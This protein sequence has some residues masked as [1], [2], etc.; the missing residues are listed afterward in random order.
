MNRGRALAAVT[1]GFWAGAVPFSNLAARR[2]AGVDLRSYGTGTVSGTGLYEVTGIA[3]LVVVGLLELGKG[4]LGPALAGPSRPVAGALAGAAAVVGHNWSPFLGGAGG[5]GI[6]PAMGALVPSAPAAAAV[7]LAGLA[8]GKLAGETA[9]GCFVADL[10]LVPLAARA[11]GRRGAL[12]AGAVLLPMVV[13]RL[14]GNGPPSQPG[15]S[16][17]WWRLLL[18]R[19]A[20]GRPADPADRERPHRPG[21]PAR[22]GL[23]EE[24]R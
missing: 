20:P 23:P 5:R 6:S 18:D 14:A 17:Y 22:P 2:L 12:A 1:A 7:L 11:H 13:K 9:V 24:R 8:V 4:A 21:L 10:A 16:V 3:P 19:D 15:L